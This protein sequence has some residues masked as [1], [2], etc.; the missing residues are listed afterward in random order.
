MGFTEFGHDV[1]NIKD[2]CI[3]LPERLRDTRYNE[4]GYNAGKQVASP[5]KI[6]SALFIA[7]ITG[8]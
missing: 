8:G 4:A 5:M 3:R 7:S 2:I 6:K 1:Q